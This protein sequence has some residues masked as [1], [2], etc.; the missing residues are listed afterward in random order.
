MLDVSTPAD[1]GA[2]VDGV[3]TVF[4]LAAD[5]G[6]MG[7]IEN[8]KALCM[9]SVLINTHMLVAARDAGVERFFYSSSACVY[10]ADK[11][12]DTDV[13][14]LREAGRLPGDARGRLRLGEAVQRADVPATSART[15][16]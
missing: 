5:M 12:T 11:Q 8:N 13:L 15:S 6:G 16:A 10:A 1:C 4:N 2:A 9:L 3:D 7:F 14:P